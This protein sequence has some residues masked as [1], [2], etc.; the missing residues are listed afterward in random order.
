MDSLLYFYMLENW[1]HQSLLFFV[2]FQIPHNFASK[3]WN[4]NKFDTVVKIEMIFFFHNKKNNLMMLYLN[5]SFLK[6]DRVSSSK[7]L[8][9]KLFFLS[10]AF[11]MILERF[12][13]LSVLKKNKKMS[14]LYTL[15]NNLK[16]FQAVKLWFFILKFVVFQ[17]YVWRLFYAFL[18]SLKDR[19]SVFFKETWLII[20]HVIVFNFL[21]EKN[22]MMFHFWTFFLYDQNILLIVRDLIEISLYIIIPNGFF[23]QV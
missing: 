8:N 7:N 5:I 15:S 14:F 17:I 4:S 23:I 13:L 9:R 11:I 6:V 22:I 2:R 10:I 20:Y 19:V 18:L 21:W 12:W 3:S 1:M 16:D